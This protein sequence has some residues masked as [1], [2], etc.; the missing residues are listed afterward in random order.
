MGLTVKNKTSYELGNNLTEF[1]SLP[2][3]EEKN[4]DEISELIDEYNELKNK[5]YM[6]DID[7]EEKANIINKINSLKSSKNKKQHIREIEEFKKIYE[8]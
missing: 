4:I 7:I 1:F 5:I 3:E 8:L 6:L 2:I